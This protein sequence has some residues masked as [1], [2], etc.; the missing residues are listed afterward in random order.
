MTMENHDFTEEQKQYLQ[1]FLSGSNVARVSRGLPDLSGA[2]NLSSGSNSH[3]NG[4]VPS[5]GVHG[6]PT[7]DNYGWQAQ[8]QTVAEGKK[9]T[10]QEEAK[11]KIH[12]LDQW[13]DIAQH[14]E[15]NRFPKG[16]DVLSF[17]YHGLF[18]VAPTQ[19]S[20]MTRLRFR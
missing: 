7:P 16:L 5:G 1:G 10:E 20:Y 13:D 14:A 4:S 19:N 2:L 3:A 17:K 8:N 9:L 6:P 12:P 11:R 15:E 18:F